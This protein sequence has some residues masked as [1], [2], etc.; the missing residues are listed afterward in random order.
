MIPWTQQ[1]KSRRAATAGRGDPIRNVRI[2]AKPL[3][4]SSGSPAKRVA[5]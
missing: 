2:D 1:R 3:P 5:Q 4:R